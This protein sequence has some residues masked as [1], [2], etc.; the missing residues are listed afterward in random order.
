MGRVTGPIRAAVAALREALTNEGIRRLEVAWMAGIA[1]DTALLVVLLVVV[2]EREGAVATGILGAL[3]M[4]PAVLAGM[5]SGAVLERVRGRPLLVALGL[6]RLASAA[7]VALVIAMDGPTELLFVLAAV[8]AAAGAP[9]RPIQATLMPALAR[10]PT[11]LVASSMAWSTGEGL[12]SFAGPFIAGVLI[13]AGAETAAA[14][15]AAAGFAITVFAAAGLRFEHAQDAAG[16]AGHAAGGLRLMDGLRALRRRP[17][18]RWTMV[19]VFGQVLTRGLLNTLAVVAAIELLR[20]GDGG[21]GLLNAA[22]GIGGLF[23]A[24]FAVSLTRTDQLVR[25]ACVSLAYWGL[26]LAVIGLLPFPAIALAAMVVIGVANAV[27][28]VAIFTIFQRGCTNEERAP[29]F[30]VFEGVAGLGAV[31][32]SLLAPVLLVAFG[33]QGALV[34]AGAILP[35]LALVVYAAI[36]RVDRIAVVDEPTVGLLRLVPI[37][38]ALP[39]TAVERVAAGLRRIDAEAGAV[40]MRQGDEGDEFL[41]IDAGEVEVSVDGRTIHRLGRGSGVGEIALLRKSPRTATVVATSAVTAYSV[42]CR[43]FLAAV[44]GP[45]AAA[46]TEHIAEAHLARSATSA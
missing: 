11:E 45:A 41:V 31:T 29:V 21:V 12:G 23:G 24:V 7:A 13:A 25:T 37:F 39:M 3:R 4:A 10:S 28:D 6:T 16:G 40:L 32:G 42:D 38:A 8:A 35:I 44:S 36:G 14:L 33:S 18:P 9:V 5:L 2:F 19:T 1:A 22:L 27:Y 26:P 34:I 15:A 20:M 46:V 43:T 30:S 17:V